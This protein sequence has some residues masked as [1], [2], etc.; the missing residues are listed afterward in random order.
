MTEPSNPFA[1]WLNASMQNRGL[2]QAEVARE[3][4]VA[5]A[6]VSRWR[7]GQVTP[8]VRYLQLLEEKIPRSLWRAYA[9][10]CEAIASELSASFEEALSKAEQTAEDT[11][12]R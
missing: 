12:G 1:Q 9:E 11:A 5:D 4:G 8:T 6:Q 3:V 10:A 7:R 2:S